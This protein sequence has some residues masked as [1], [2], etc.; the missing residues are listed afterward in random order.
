VLPPLEPEPPKPPREPVVGPA[1]R[2]AGAA[3]G[4]GLGAFA[5]LAWRWARV[6]AALVLAGARAAAGQLVLAARIARAHAP[7]VGRF[8]AQLA[9]FAIAVV[10]G[11]GRFVAAYF[12]TW[13]GEFA[14]WRAS[15]R[16]QDSRQEPPQN[17][18]APSPNGHQPGAAPTRRKPPSRC[19]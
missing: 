14:A 17:V 10:A 19:G 13:R 4:R 5:T 15:R 2:A 16:W 18:R 9:A 1:L 3:S 12:R 8:L 6:A 11:L 7:T